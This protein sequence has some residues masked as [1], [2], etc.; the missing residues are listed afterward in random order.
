[1]LDSAMLEHS[2]LNYH[3]LRN[4]MTTSIARDDLL[5]FLVATNHAPLIAAVSSEPAARVPPG[6]AISPPI[7][8]A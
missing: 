2:P 3:P 6:S 8:L 1:M 7:R 5:R 4:T